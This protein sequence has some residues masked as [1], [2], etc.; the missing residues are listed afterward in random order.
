VF[1]KTFFVFFRL[2]AK[3]KEVMTM[4]DCL[5]IHV[6]VLSSRSPDVLS[7]ILC[8]AR[9]IQERSF[10]LPIEMLIVRSFRGQS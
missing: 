8:P 6:W 9:V 7:F 5:K 4:D 1:W 3:S 2:L 10:L